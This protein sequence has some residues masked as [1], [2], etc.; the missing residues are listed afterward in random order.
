MTPQAPSCSYGV[1]DPP[2]RRNQEYLEPHINSGVASREWQGMRRDLRTR[3]GNIPTVCFFADRDGLGRPLKRAMPA[4]QDAANL[5]EHEAAV[6]QTGATML[7]HLRIGEGV[8]AVLA[9]KTR[10]ARPLTL[11]HTAKERLE[12]L[13]QPM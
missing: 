1:P 6:I 5:R 10:I 4:H 2:V 9:L 8:V 11:P 3:E 12:R 7:P 13:I